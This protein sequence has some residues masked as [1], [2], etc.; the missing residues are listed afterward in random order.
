MMRLIQLAVTVGTV[1]MSVES[2]GQPIDCAIFVNGQRLPSVRAAEGTA[3]SIKFQG[4]GFVFGASA[5]NEKRVKVTIQSSRLKHEGFLIGAFRNGVLEMSP[6][7]A[8]QQVTVR[9]S[10]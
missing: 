7:I 8:G 3:E 6:D 10:K 2:W 1:L 9:C 5:L 4:A